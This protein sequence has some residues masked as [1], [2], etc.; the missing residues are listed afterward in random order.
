VAPPVH[1]FDRFELD[2]DERRLLTD[3][4][5][6]AVGPRAFEVLAVLVE[7]AG[8]LV[9]KQ[10]LLDRAWPNLI[11]AENNLQVQVSALRRI[12]GPETIATIPGHGYRFTAKLIGNDTAPADSAAA[13]AVAEKQN[14][15]HQFTSFVGRTREIPEIEALLQK[16]RLLTLVGFGGIGKTRLALQTAASTVSGYQEGAWLVELAPLADALLVPQAIATVL[17]V[18]EEAGRPVL[19]ALLKHLKNRR[20]LLLL[21]S[22]EHLLGVCAEVSK[23]LLQ[24]SPHLT[25]LAT[26]RERLNLLGETIYPV[27]PLRL[28]EPDLEMSLE[29]LGQYEAVRLF[30]DR[31]SAAEPAFRL[32]DQNATA[33]ADICRRVDG[34]PLAIEL[35]AA[36]VRVLSPEK[37][38]MRL[39]D[40]FRLLTRGDATTL[41]HR[42]TLRALIDWSYELLTELQRALLRRLAV[43][44]GSF[45]LEAAE[46]VGAGGEIAEADVLD[47]LTDL[48]EKSLV[49]VEADGGRYRLL[50]TVREYAHARCDEAGDGDAARD[51][52]LAFYFA[53]AEEALPNVDGRMQ[54]DWFTKLDREREN[55]LA[56]HAWCARTTNG[57]ETALRLVFAMRHYWIH[58]GGLEIG[59]GLATQ[60]LRE[61][62]VHARGLARCEGVYAA[63][64]FASC[65]GRYP[66]AQLYLEE[67]LS[68]AREIGDRERIAMALHSL[69]E[70]LYAQGKL[71]EARKYFESALPIARQLDT[72][73]AQTAVLAGLAELSRLEGNLEIATSLF[74]E[75]LVL[76]RECGDLADV[77]ICLINLAS[78][79]MARGCRER[80]P[81]LL[82]EAFAVIEETGS[83][84]LGAI[85]LQ[86]CS[87]LAAFSGEWRRAAQ[88]YGMAYAQ[89]ERLGYR[90]DPAD[91]ALLSPLIAKAREALG[92]RAFAA[93]EAAGQS[94]SYEAALA[95]ARVWLERHS[96]VASSH[97]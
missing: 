44:P 92:V 62:P 11:V 67:S 87:G 33:V 54:A 83:K 97:P 34:I 95:E 1:R 38:A 51:R 76:A 10:E 53:L 26:S 57:F 20:L 48:I 14:L 72:K 22:C 43:F 17:G 45:T 41:P 28:P 21:D 84:L 35:A 69:G 12:L 85:A 61:A 56:A 9:S 71:D 58:H 55:C 16:T 70:Q 79:L 32:T 80:P 65:M 30:V 29:A 86:I 42:Q 19:E 75:G 46:A 36:R 5:A 27:Q 90:T 50:D 15:P 94:L 49:V 23:Q 25:I 37:I 59:Y 96:E 7:R 64:K 24:S 91:E 2:T 77:V 93:A 60:A 81:K 78:V 4:A 88:L 52:H 6:V 63:A 47:L 31:A 73:L 68:I 82:L 3:G 40:R 66:E 89:V 39:H 13:A 8:R 18:R 74:D